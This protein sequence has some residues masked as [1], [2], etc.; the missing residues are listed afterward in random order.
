MGA[1]TLCPKCGHEP[2]E[3]EDLAKHL[4]TSDHYLS[5]DQL[6]GI[7]QRIGSG[8]PV[9]FREGDVTS[10]VNLIQRGKVLKKGRGSPV[11]NIFSCMAVWIFLLVSIFAIVYFLGHTLLKG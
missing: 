7:S 4:M 8:L 3:D 6:Q 2:K 11:L 5:G 9:T 1:F 10:F